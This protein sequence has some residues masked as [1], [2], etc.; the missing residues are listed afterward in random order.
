MATPDAQE[1]AARQR[2]IKHMNADHLD[3]VRRYLEAYAKKSILQTRSAQMT[4]ISLNEMKF[5]CNGQ[6]HVIAFDPPMKSLREARE[7]VVELDKDALQILGRSDVSVD[8]YIP[9]YVKFGHYWNFTQCVLAYVLLPYPFV[10]QHGSVLY[11][12]FLYRFPS[13]AN[14]IASVGWY[15]VV[16]IMLPLHFVEAG[17]MARRLRIKHGL[18]PL[19]GVWWLWVSSCFIEGVTAKWRLDGLVEQKKKEKEAKKH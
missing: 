17:F 16:F 15:V 10:W 5:S 4:D 9:P 19:D 6:Q 12:S 1:D 8:K 18:I 13:F 14:L 2:I 11:D 7:R 3:S